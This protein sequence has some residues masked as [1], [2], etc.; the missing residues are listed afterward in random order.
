MARWGHNG[1]SSVASWCLSGIKVGGALQL[2]R[3]SCV[4]TIYV[5]RDLDECRNTSMAFKTARMSLQ[6]SATSAVDLCRTRIGLRF[7][8][9]LR[10]E[11]VVVELCVNLGDDGLRE[12]AYRGG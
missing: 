3:T 6:Y 5:N 11:G 10:I 2:P 8:R 1:I 4:P 7:T 9:H 12:A